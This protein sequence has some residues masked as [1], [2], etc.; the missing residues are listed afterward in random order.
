MILKRGG[1]G[2]RWRLGRE[3]VVGE[4]EAVATWKGGGGRWKVIEE[5]L[6]SIG[7]QQ[8]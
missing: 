2:G 4:E 5:S 6:D 3:E 7:E 1:G 8:K